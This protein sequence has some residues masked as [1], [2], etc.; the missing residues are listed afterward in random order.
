[1]KKNM[2]SCYAAL[3]VVI[4]LAL[5][6][7]SAWAADVEI[8]GNASVSGTLNAGSFSG[9]FSGSG[10]GLTGI[11][12]TAISSTSITDTQLHDNAVTSAKIAN[13]AVTSAKIAFFSK[14]AIVAASGGDYINPAT[15]MGDYPNWC[16]TP[17]A[18]NPC[19]LKIMP[20]V[21]TV[22]SSVVMQPYIDIEGSGENTTFIQG[23]IDSTSSG[24]VN[25]ANNAE[26]RFLTITNAGGGSS[27]VGFYNDNTSPNITN[28]TVTASG[29]SVGNAGVSNNNSSSPVMLNVNVTAAG[30]GTT[31]NN[32]AVVNVTFSS[33][34]MRH[35]IAI[36]TGGS[37]ARGIYND[38][39]T[40][41]LTNSTVKASGGASSNY[42]IYNA[43]GAG[44][45]RINR[46]TVKAT[47]TIASSASWIVLVSHTQLDGGLPP[48]GA[49]TITCVGAFNT[50][51]V[52][53]STTCQ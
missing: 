15:A 30:G 47:N 44:T 23:S 7:Q 24:I 25:G 19:L 6:M 16:G 11:P 34:S 51:Y 10:A 5:F 41:T 53:L 20:G 28:V 26:I 40:P 49:Y 33:P 17:S 52:G 1:M 4:L 37:S 8:N 39:S 38:S 21:Y 32:L 2:I 18:T 48:L 50:S 3:F 9:S 42:G 35:V 31:P 45:I 29:G 27:T 22:S 14:V 46:S 12:G 43:N 36:A 13:D